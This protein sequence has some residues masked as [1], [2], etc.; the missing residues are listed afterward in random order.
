MPSKLFL[1]GRA[2]RLQNTLPEILGVT[3]LHTKS[4]HSRI[5]PIATQ[6]L[7]CCPRSFT[8]L[9]FPDPT[10]FSVWV[11]LPRVLLP[12]LS[13]APVVCTSLHGRSLGRGS[14]KAEASPLRLFSTSFWRQSLTE[15]GAG[16][17]QLVWLASKPP[18]I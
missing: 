8:L 3:D 6:L 14:S 13:A 18:R 12:Q 7:N 2:G 10:V 5:T 11:S 17:S 16:C 15:S 1:P 4:L 9:P